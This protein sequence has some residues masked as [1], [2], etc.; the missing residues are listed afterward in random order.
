MSN[1]IGIICDIHL[2]GSTSS[3]QYLFLK[4]ALDMLKASDV[5]TLI[6]LG[7]VTAYGETLGRQVYEELVQQFDYYEV[8][9]N[10]DVRDMY[11]AKQLI[12]RFTRDE[13]FAAGRKFIGIHTPYAIISDT[14]RKRLSAISPGDVI[15]LHHDIDSLEAESREYLIRLIAETPVLVLH[16]HLHRY[17]DYTIGDSRVVGV[18]CLDPDKCIASFPCVTYLDFL[19]DDI[20]ICEQPITLSTK[21]MREASQYFGISCVDN[22]VDVEYALEHGIRYVELRCVDDW[23]PDWSIIPLITKWKE[24]TKG[25]LS[26]HMPDI[27]IKDGN[28]VGEAQWNQALQY[29]SVLKADGLTMHTPRVKQNDMP[30][31]SDI[32]HKI[33][34]L[35][36]DAVKNIGFNVKVGIENLHVN[37]GEKVD[38]NRG[39][40]YTPEEVSLWIDS[41]NGILGIK[42]R[43]GHVL[44]VGH[45]RNN[46]ALAEVYPISRWYEN[47]GNKTV[48]YHIHQVVPEA[49]G[50]KNHCPLENWFGPMIN[51]TSFFLSWQTGLLNHVPVFLEVKG[52]RNFEKSIH[53]FNNFLMECELL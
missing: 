37:K 20:H 51:Y 32:W 35:Y 4:Y 44:D 31:G 42:N 36:T 47:M 52:H 30:Y 15:F 9:G 25:Y 26:V 8:V 13:F 43:V 12:E 38:P 5:N 41:I 14:D 48:A 22:Q 23:K 29:A 24:Q 45:A 3:P 50:Y 2:N 34:A 19:D 7:D 27:R 28:V 6:C 53:A 1:K 46:G 21:I 40:G 49:D 16:G 17:V 11:T 39:F 10:S 33:L 18:K